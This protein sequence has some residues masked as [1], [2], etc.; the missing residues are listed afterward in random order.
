M[1]MKVT[2]GIETNKGRK[3]WICDTGEKAH[4][5]WKGKHIIRNLW[6]APHEDF[7]GYFYWV[8]YCN[9]F[10]LVE[11]DYEADGMSYC[12]VLDEYGREYN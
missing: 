5:N 9:Q 10:N 6:Y 7:K 8:R 2:A 3:L 4:I 1:R 11:E 12:H